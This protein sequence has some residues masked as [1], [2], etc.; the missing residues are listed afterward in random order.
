[1]TNFVI[2]ALPIL[3]EQ[4]YHQL[5]R[6]ELAGRTGLMIHGLFPNATDKFSREIFWVT[7]FSS[8]P[9]RGVKPMTC[10]RPTP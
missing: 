10:K 1:M 6:S 2:E 3:H 7:M 4:T 8:P 9:A 5:L